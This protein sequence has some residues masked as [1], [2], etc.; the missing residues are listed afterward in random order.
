MTS[1]FSAI[2]LPRGR[3]WKSKQKTASCQSLHHV[4]DASHVAIEADQ[5]EIHEL[6]AC[7]KVLVE[8]FPDIQPA[9]FREMLIHLGPESRLELVAE[10]LLKEKVRWVKG[11]I[12][13]RT[14]QATEVET[15]KS[16]KRGLLACDAALPAEETFRSESYK[17][18]VR[19]ILIQE[20]KSLSKSSIEAVLAE[21]NFSYF[22]S[23]ATLL[24]IASKSWRYSAFNFFAR[25]KASRMGNI[26]LLLPATGSDGR[27]Q[28]PGLQQTSS[29]ELNKEIHDTIV[30][31]LQI[32]QKEKQEADDEKYARQLNEEQAKEVEA[33]Y[34]CRCCY[35][36]TP[37]ESL[38]VCS[39]AGHEICS[40][41]IRQ[42]INSA[43]FGQN[44]AAT[45]ALEKTTIRC[46]A[47]VSAECQGVIDVES[48]KRA[49]LEE[50]NGEGI[51]RK[52][53]DRMINENVVKSQIP[54]WKCPFCIYAEVDE[55]G[56]TQP[57]RA[58]SKTSQ[59][60]LLIWIYLVLHK[61][62]YLNLCAAFFAIILLLLL[63]A[64]NPIGAFCRSLTATRTTVA[65]RRR[66]LK[67]ICQNPQCRV[68]SC[69]KCQAP[70]RDP[71]TC[72]ETEMTSLRIAIERA[73]ADAV[74]RT[75]PSCHTSFIKE[76]GCN[77][78]RCTCGYTMCYVC[79]QHI[80]EKTG[81]SHFCTHFRLV[82]GSA[83]SSCD[84]CHLYQA[85][86]DETVAK[87][88]AAKA[89]KEWRERAGEV[90][91]KVEGINQKASTITEFFMIKLA[92]SD[93]IRIGPNELHFAQ[94]QAYHD[95]YNN[96]NRW[97]KDWRLYH[98]FNEDR[99]SFGFVTYKESKER[100][101]VLNRSFSPKAVEQAEH[102]V[103]EKIEALSTVFTRHS[104][105]NTPVDLYLAF[106]CLTLDI[107]TLLCFG[108]SIDA[109]NHPGFH[110]P[111]VD[112]MDASS[113]T[114]IRFKHFDWYKNMI[115]GCPAEV[116]KVLSPITSGLVD[117]QQMLQRQI[118]DLTNDPEQLRKLPHETTI[119]HR[120]LDKEAHKD[121]VM[122]SPG[123]LYEEAQAMMFAGTD[124]VANT[125]LVGFFHLLR[126]GEEYNKLRLELQQAWPQIASPPSFRELESSHYLNAVIKESLRLS[127]GV[128]S[129]LLRVVPAAGAII[130]ELRVPG[131]TVVSCGSTFV[132]YNSK[133][134]PD[135][136]TFRPE[137]WLENPDL[138]NWLVAFS[139]GPR[140]CL[141]INLAWAEL[142]LAFAHFF[143]R[144]DLQITDDS[145][146]SLPFREAFLPWY[147]GPHL[148]AFAKPVHG[149][150]PQ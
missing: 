93:V 60:I 58:P 132:H 130:C 41:C 76:S 61:V 104:T 73:K 20:F 136:Y 87:K 71:H 42:A 100:K 149:T 25:R 64:Y 55:I 147:Y 80:P 79:R 143:R 84:R 97:D 11:R 98:S 47:S 109:I 110:A 105:T 19:D 139:R 81:Y 114:F 29:N 5:N 22:K 12:R 2:V 59:Q 115:L 51:W 43:L 89:E 48:V 49:L 82:P 4:R 111:I 124:T 148:K 30:I 57:L 36:D 108:T 106:R 103:V 13:A 75:C 72:Y 144:F 27:S 113:P 26:P 44:W 92:E 118:R 99:S 123:S 16:E 56:N 96:K 68:R 32:Q 95:I 9:V 70:W 50:A 24:E 83:C 86:D 133:I 1:V 38:S 40:R 66:G 74:K 37:F 119:Y 28:T 131:E 137:R 140:M 117:L 18:A 101:D 8:I 141:G 65:R 52:F 46:M 67:F 121:K 14:R 10:H 107:I 129:G 33:L 90:G 31:P 17:V 122:P 69:I 45:I 112:A 120:L 102:I 138:D 91:K 78:M 145:P 39:A 134:F 6:N 54:L 21:C 62:L 77:K 88:A 53:E 7:L 135:P 3:P 116:S 23:R 94:P 85:E 35:T 146:G 150:K 63:W 125:L 126:Q 127:S 34:E 128:V 15:V 142:R